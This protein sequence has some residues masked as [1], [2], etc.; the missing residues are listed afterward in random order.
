MAQN[1]RL[2]ALLAATFFLGYMAYQSKPTAWV[3]IW[4]ILN[5]SAWS[6]ELIAANRKRPL[7]LVS[8]EQEVV[9]RHTLRFWFFLLITLIDLIFLFA[10]AT[11]AGSFTN[12]V[13]HLLTI[14]S[15][16]CFSWLAYESLRW[17][18]P[19]QKLI[20]WILGSCLFG[21]AAA[22]SVFLSLSLALPISISDAIV[23]SGVFII[24]TSVALIAYMMQR[25]SVEDRVRNDVTRDVILQILGVEQ[26]ND[27][28]NEIARHIHEHLRYEHVFILEPSFDRSL[29]TVVAEAGNY[30]NVT[31][32][33]LSVQM[34]ITGKAFL[35]NL[36]LAWNDIKVCPYYHR[37]LEEEKDDTRAEIAIPLQYQGVT[38]GVL[39][40]QA[41]HPNLFRWED[42]VTLQVIARVLAV[43]LASQK[44]DM[45]IQE[46]SQLWDEL[47]NQYY[48]E[49]AIF[50]EFALFAQEKLGA[51]VI[52]Y[53]PLSPTGFPVQP[54]FHAGALFPER[55]I[56]TIQ[57]V[58]SPLIKLIR[59]WKPYFSD[60]I[61]PKSI[62][63]QMSKNDPPSF[64][65]RERVESAC[66]IPVGTTRERLGAL[67]LNYR[68]P[69][70]F[71][72][73]FKFMVLSFAQ[74][75]AILASRERYRTILFEGFGR[76]ELG[77][78]NLLNRYSLK[79]G[80]VEEGR[81]I[82]QH[83]C[84][85]PEP[86]ERSRRD[87]DELL[88]RMEGFLQAVSLTHSAIPPMFWR[89][90]LLEEVREFASTLPFTKRGQRPMTNINIDSRI[91]RESPFVKLAIYR[92]ITEGMNN[93]VVHGDTNEIK[94][95]VGRE[96]SRISVTIVNDGVPL[97]IDA[98]AK[99]SKRGIYSLLDDL[100]T[101]M[102]AATN[103]A[104]RLD[105]EGTVVEAAFPALPLQAEE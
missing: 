34:G 69:R 10:I 104:R 91:E 3:I 51:D 68:Q 27:Q 2:F 56:H 64:A 73:L 52:T 6:W 1:F 103:I 13:T 101:T 65:V 24:Y 30:P 28:W 46:A 61:H 29:L 80:V 40:V 26:S 36:P 12:L 43:A 14:Y 71:D 86:A 81:N 22:A 58:K 7:L 50:D 35:E 76:P 100:K 41:N 105:N 33:A 20:W 55:M 16:L 42:V 44:T 95:V 5:L 89:E 15:I 31:G 18:F 72:G 59:D 74:I 66:F 78:H 57:D 48:T 4:A 54:P 23:V 98:Q 17:N 25:L 70:K 49:Q 63:A 97:S 77:V 21:L 47:S 102:G 90:S 93:A 85:D 38:Y 82:L 84:G 11:L 87:M 9:K 94:V 53:Y 67:F 75:F 62:F 32:Q 99:R 79:S 88:Y 92:L 39:D 37:L 8:P 83:L 60:H 45:L 19:D 96:D